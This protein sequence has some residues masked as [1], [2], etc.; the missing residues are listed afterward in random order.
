MSPILPSYMQEEQPEALPAAGGGQPQLGSMM[1][2]LLGIPMMAPRAAAAMG[3][4]VLGGLGD[5]V[6]MP[7]DLY[8][9]SQRN[10]LVKRLKSY[11]FKPEDDFFQN[12]LQAFDKRT[13]AR[14]LIPDTRNFRKLI[15]TMTGG[16]TKAKEGEEFM[17]RMFEI[18]GSFM[19][20]LGVFSLPK[21]ITKVPGAVKKMAEAGLTGTA[22][23]GIKKGWE[24]LA[25]M[26]N[27]L[28][29]NAPSN[30]A[31]EEMGKGIITFGTKLKRGLAL[32]AVGATGDLAFQHIESPVGRAA[33]QFG[34][35]AASSLAMPKKMVDEGLKK[36]MGTLEDQY[37]KGGIVSVEKFSKPARTKL[38]NFFGT[39]D[40]ADYTE[41]RKVTS[42]FF[43]KAEAREKIMTERPK[44]AK[45][46]KEW[47]KDREIENQDLQ[48]KVDKQAANKILYKDRVTSSQR[49]KINRADDL[50]DQLQIIEKEREGLKGKD[51]SK[52]DQ[53]EALEKT[54]R[55]S[56]QKL[57]TEY[58][59]KMINKRV[60]EAENTKREE[61]TRQAQRGKTTAEDLA[62]EE[63]LIGERILEK[64]PKGVA[65]KE[66]FHRLK[67][68][69]Q[70]KEYKEEDIER[71]LSPRKINEEVE[72]IG[73][74]TRAKLEEAKKKLQESTTK[75]AKKRAVAEIKKQKD[76]AGDKLA[77]RKKKAERELKEIE[78]ELKQSIE[79]PGEELDVSI[80]KKENQIR[81]L[82]QKIE[83]V[84]KRLES[85]DLSDAALQDTNLTF[86]E[87]AAFLR[88]SKGIESDIF[89]AKTSK[90]SKN[91]MKKFV[92]EFTKDVDKVFKEELKAYD[93]QTGTNLFK[94]YTDLTEAYR[95]NNHLPKIHRIISDFLKKNKKYF[96]YGVGFNIE[97][98]L[99]YIA[100][101]ATGYPF[102][103]VYKGVNNIRK[104]GT[105]P[106]IRDMTIDFLKKTSAN[107][108]AAAIKAANRLGR[109]LQR[110]DDKRGRYQLLG[111]MK[112]Q[113][114]A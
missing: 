61:L 66:A 45:Q 72:K 29:I 110:D 51:L 101:I 33:A 71:K 78:E 39:E 109:E 57:E 111:K 35:L 12:Q 4:S 102:Y 99:P 46:L 87:I 30:K 5:L 37:P 107:H 114:A 70:R 1:S 48:R 83:E 2:T 90:Q 98:F 42:P 64:E 95:V 59:D 62:T 68:K 94:T 32:G 67:K 113:K 36:R 47:L 52:K 80:L 10:K 76:T 43:K 63:G 75:S 31:A 3:S 9:A 34:L 105:S 44:A 40:T 21:A 25:K 50:T 15:D 91:I 74:E 77:L 8:H 60:K 56:R 20:P 6:A 65:R 89:M 93:A 28:K 97:K 53:I 13:I 54:Q 69:G 7:F 49:K 96:A 92:V 55:E 104:F 26:A 24:N 88:N 73:K 58:T 11:G 108:T 100:K 19:S 86:K 84:Q 14:N 106:I 22:K 103:A 82:D 27:P 23:E 41:A 112:T 17:E 38:K 79:N 85:G 16:V 18:G 81:K